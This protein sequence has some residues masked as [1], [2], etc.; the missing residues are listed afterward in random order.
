MRASTATTPATA[1]SSPERISS[2][3]PIRAG[4]ARLR[5]RTDMSLLLEA[6]KKAERAKE[7]AQR[8]GRADAEGAAPAEPIAPPPRVAPAPEPVIT[9]DQ[10]PDVRQPLSLEEDVQPSAKPAPA[11]KPASASQSSRR[12]EPKPDALAADAQRNSARKV[13]EAKFKEPDP[14]LP[15]FITMGALGLFAVGTVVYFWLQLNPAPA[16]VNANPP[17]PSNETQIAAADLKPAPTVVA[18]AAPASAIPG[19]PAATVAPAAPAKPT[20]V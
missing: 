19:L 11:A 8:R 5:R 12:A 10:L 2:A 17:R 4:R 7:E 1:T 18:P 16:L 14:R 9:R 13:F 6:L 15:F 3:S 20:V